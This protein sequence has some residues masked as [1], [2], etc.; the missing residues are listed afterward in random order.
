MGHRND[1][2]EK[3]RKN[4]FI[5]LTIRR[6]LSAYALLITSLPVFSI[7]M[8]AALMTVS[9]C[10]VTGPVRPYDEVGQDKGR[11]ETVLRLK[12]AEG[13]SPHIR[14]IDLFIFND[15]ALKRLDSYQ[16]FDTDI[17][18][19]VTAASRKGKKILVAIANS[20]KPAEDW[21]GINSIDAIMDVTA[22][23]R[24]E[25]PDSMT[26]G[27]TA[28]ADMGV[29][30]ECSMVLTPLISGIYINSIRC[31][32]SGRPYEGLELHDARVYLTNVN[33]SARIFA[34]D[35]FKPISIINAGRLSDT[36][37]NSLSCPEMLLKTID[38]NIGD[39]ACRIGAALYC[40]PNDCP[41][42]TAGSPFTR[43]V[44]EGSL[45]GKTY[46]YPVNINRPSAG[47]LAA[48]KNGISRNC[49]YIYDITVTRSG[50]TDPDIVADP[51]M[52]QVRCDI[53]P[54]EELEED[55]IDF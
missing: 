1:I 7:Y 18:N 13:N 6:V 14:E 26:M 52:I 41:E 31:D 24:N 12:S 51:S 32:F 34:E 27:G 21:A 43:L 10:S 33:A 30:M 47:A 36:D 9:G 5:F 53:L 35:G 3:D 54:W 25:N 46:Y 19:T 11:H 8:P 40:Y 17:G 37:M 55:E 29:D 22:D 49:R 42:E 39:E 2:R 4:S 23:L 50:T 28:Y 20:G 16:K 45:D 48:G 38:G 44:I 15:D